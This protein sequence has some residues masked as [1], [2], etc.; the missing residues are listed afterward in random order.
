MNTRIHR[1]ESSVQYKVCIAKIS[2]FV[3]SGADGDVAGGASREEVVLAAPAVPPEL[4]PVSGG[5]RRHRSLRLV[6]VG[7]SATAIG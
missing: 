5:R 6:R 3:L 7:R 2:K 4:S 1:H